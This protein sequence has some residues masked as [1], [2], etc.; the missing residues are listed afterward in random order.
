[1]LL[2]DFVHLPA[3]L[4]LGIIVVVLAG[5]IWFSLAADRRDARE[6]LTWTRHMPCRGNLRIR[7]FGGLE[8]EGVTEKELGSRKART[9]V[10]VLA[11]ARGTPVSADRIVDAL[12][13]EQPPARPLDQV[14][15]LVSRLRP[16]I[17]AERLRRTD[18]G[19]SL[20]VGWLDVAEL[21]ARVDEAC[22]A[23]RRRQPR[24][25][26]RRSIG[27]AHARPRRAAGRR[28]RRTVGGG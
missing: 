23:H 14:G 11:L 28:A 20:D 27:R 18:A 2:S 7:L 16:V 4:S 5:G 15:V 12:W 8:V 3:L 21:E 19:W 17:G 10:K 9:L 13:P 1:M 26:A 24:G 6:P 25:S 22:G